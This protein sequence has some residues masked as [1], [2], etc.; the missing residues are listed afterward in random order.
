MKDNL[1]L[2]VNEKGKLETAPI[3]LLKANANYTSTIT[4]ITPAP[5]DNVV[6]ANFNKRNSVDWN[7]SQYLIPSGNKKGKDILDKTHDLYQK[8]YDWNVFE[9]IIES[10]AVAYFAKYRA[11]LLYVSI[12]VGEQQ[13]PELAENYKGVFNYNNPLP[14][15]AENGDYYIS[16]GYNFNDKNIKWTL[17]DIAYYWNGWKK[18]NYIGTF[19]TTS[20][21]VPVDPNIPANVEIVA[22]QDLAALL[23]GKVATIEEDIVNLD[24]LTQEHRI[25]IGNLE[26]DNEINKTDIANL[27]LKDQEQDQRLDNI[28]SVIGNGGGGS[29]YEPDGATI[30][31]NEDDKLEVNLKEIMNGGYL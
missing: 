23:A 6:M 24:I 8:V 25:R 4:V 27:K 14:E 1:I 16:N 31:L 29:G 18:S 13:T 10:K 3:G 30:V 12:G 21:A 7:V 26:N 19:N 28:E 11:D 9:G 5:L 2:I 22:D 20:V 17:N 15:T